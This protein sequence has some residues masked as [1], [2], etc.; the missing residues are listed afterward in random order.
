MCVG[1]DKCVETK[2]FRVYIG[3]QVHVED[4]CF[5]YITASKSIKMFR[6]FFG[7]FPV[8]RW[9]YVRNFITNL[10]LS[11]GL[12]LIKEFICFCLLLSFFGCVVWLP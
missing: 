3:T 8:P 6:V 7:P 1:P 10:I 9:V 5:V 2:A 11:Y 12:V 4:I